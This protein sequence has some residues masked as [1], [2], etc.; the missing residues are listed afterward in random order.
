MTSEHFDIDEFE[1]ALDGVASLAFRASPP[2]VLYHYT[3]WAGLE[4]ILTSRRF[5]FT[6]HRCTNDEAELKSCDETIV[7]VVTTLTHSRRGTVRDLL[8]VLLSNYDAH[9]KLDAAIEVF[10]ACFSEVRDS[11]T[12]WDKYGDEGRGFCLGIPV[13]TNELPPEYPDLGQ[14]LCPVDYSDTSWRQR[15][16]QGLEKVCQKVAEVEARCGSVPIESKRLA[17]NAMSR[18]AAAAA[19]A[20]KEAKWAVEKEWRHVVMVPAGAHEVKTDGRAKRYIELSMRRDSKT[21]MLDEIMIGPSQDADLA[22]G[23]LATILASAGY[24]NE[25]AAMP[26]IVTSTTGPR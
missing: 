15:V 21:L 8:E 13:L 7:N 10:M 22:R 6:S 1:K 17:L 23:R 11:A 18:I 9:L 25:H 20:A 2:P 3:N 16:T 14:A 26:R 12:Q 19:V 24:P 5:R 4:G